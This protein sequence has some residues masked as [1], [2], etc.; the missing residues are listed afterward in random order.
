M[1]EVEGVRDAAHRLEADEV[2]AFASRRVDNGGV[3]FT[4]SRIIF[5]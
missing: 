3:I 4:E 5:S 2:A 1:R